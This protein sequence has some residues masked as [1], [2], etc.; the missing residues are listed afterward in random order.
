MLILLKKLF[1]LIW[2][3]TMYLLKSVLGLLFIIMRFILTLFDFSERYT[4]KSDLKGYLDQDTKMRKRVDRLFA[5]Y[6]VPKK[7]KE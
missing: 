6:G 1:S 4:V 2:I 5:R 3:I 7:R